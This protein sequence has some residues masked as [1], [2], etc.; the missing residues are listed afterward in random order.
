MDFC[1]NEAH[2]VNRMQGRRRRLIGVALLMLLP[3]LS[4]IGC[5]AKRGYPAA[6]P[7]TALG[8]PGECA[9]CH[10]KIDRV[11]KE[12]LVTFDAVEYIVCDDTCA[13]GLRVAPDR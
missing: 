8:H 2:R 6:K 1:R 13:E 11:A 10:K 9:Y 7:A 4:T 5:G 12:N 3:A